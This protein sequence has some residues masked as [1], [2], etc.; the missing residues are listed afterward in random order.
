LRRVSQNLDSLNLMQ[1][2]AHKQQDAPISRSATFEIHS[3]GQ[4]SATPARMTA[5]IIT[6]AIAV[7]LRNFSASLRAFLNA[8]RV[9][10]MASR[11]SSVNRAAKL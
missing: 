11:G 3:F 1:F 6:S 7:G 8:S 10:A 9:S 2:E 5:E 4:T